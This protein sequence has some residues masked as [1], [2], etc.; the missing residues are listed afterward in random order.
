MSKSAWPSDVTNKLEQLYEGDNEA[1]PE[2][3]ETLDKTVAAVRA[4]LVNMKIYVKPETPRKVGGASSIRKA[5]IVRDIAKVVD[6]PHDSL[7]S[8]QNA[9]KPTLEALLEAIKK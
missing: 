5:H 3:A 8:L 6:I 1:I 9:T 7:E 4:K 2:I